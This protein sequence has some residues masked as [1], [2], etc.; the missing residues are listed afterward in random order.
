MKIE[1]VRF[2]QIVN[3]EPVKLSLRDGD[4]LRCSEGGTTDEGYDVTH[5]QW[6][7]D[8]D[9]LTMQ[10]TR[11]AR[12]CDGETYH[13]GDYFCDVSQANGRAIAHC[14]T[15][16]QHLGGFASVADCSFQCWHCK[17]VRKLD[18]VRIVAFM[19]EWECDALENRDYS[20]EAAGY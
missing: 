16:D 9:T 2:W 13:S 15:C 6:E 20:A 14:A 19:P 12:D 1:T 5:Y 7:R 3:H 4:T 17:A 11:N 8:G 10:T 18:G